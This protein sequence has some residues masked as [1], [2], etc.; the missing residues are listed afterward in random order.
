VNDVESIIWR[1]TFAQRPAG[2]HNAGALGSH[3]LHRGELGAG[4]SHRDVRRAAPQ[5]EFESKIEAIL[6]QS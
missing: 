4:A 1:A 6:K 3:G 5:V 2:A